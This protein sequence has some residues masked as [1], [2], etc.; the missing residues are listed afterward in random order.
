MKQSNSENYLA[1]P[2]WLVG[3]RIHEVAFC[4]AF[5]EDHPMKC[6]RSRLFTVDGAVED[7]AEISNQILTEIAP[8]QSSN[9]SKT[10][11]DSETLLFCSIL[12]YYT[13]NRYNV[14]IT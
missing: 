6:I 8:Y 1:K 7:E 10:I 14:P 13:K 9:V 2:S 11:M 4:D 12:D 5:L 3:K